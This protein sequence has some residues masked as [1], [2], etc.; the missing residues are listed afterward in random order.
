M[1]KITP[2]TLRD[3]LVP[4][5]FL[6]SSV[7]PRLDNLKVKL[8]KDVKAYI[9]A[10]IEDTLM[11]ERSWK[12]REKLNANELAKLEKDGLT[13]M[14]ELPEYA[15]KDIS[16][17]DKFT[18]E[19]FKWSGIYAQRPK[20]AGYFL[21]RIKCPSGKISAKQALK[22]A[23]I[24][25]KWG[26]SSIQITVRQCIQIH[27]IELKNL[28]EVIKEINEAG[29]TTIQGCG[30]VPRN[31]LG[32][33]L[34]GI[35]PDEI[36]DT[37]P[38]IDAV[39]KEMVGNYLYSNLPRKFKIS[40]SANPH[41]S[42]F[43]AIND[44]AFT[45]AILDKE[46][47]TSVKGFHV[48]IGGGLSRDPMLAQKLPFFIKPEEVLEVTK[49]T[50]VIF[51]EYG[52]RENRMHCRLKFLVADWG[53]EKLEEELQKITGPLEKGGRDVVAP[54]NLGVFH[55]VHPQKQEGLSYVG[56]HLPLGVTVA[57]KLKA[58]AELAIKYGSGEPQIRTT[59]SQN[60]LIINIPN[61]KTADLVKEPNDNGISTNPHNISGYAKSCTGITYCNFATTDT[62][63]NLARIL[64]E[65]EKAFPDFPVPLRI[66]LTGCTNS[67][68]QIQ[69]ADIGLQGAKGKEGNM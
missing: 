63:H 40:I 58:I 62:K 4:A 50:A 15:K 53:N 2:G 20:T 66:Y 55:G 34:M 51:R 7:S 37:A 57:E 39:N 45:P 27:N 43:A 12:N 33:P 49:A 1:V 65:L 18:I 11:E 5:L 46:D 32:N 38:L 30:D 56:V 10:F 31:V 14:Q 19:R 35:D 67:C 60:I 61:E 26:E 52:Y 69:I 59:N 64:S 24:S 28:P 41:D 29:L 17:L 3:S 44:I 36:L 42:A 54:W 68:A 48:W 13:I 23:E 25:K 9:K 16:E 47:G 8:T 21:T 22:V 6:L